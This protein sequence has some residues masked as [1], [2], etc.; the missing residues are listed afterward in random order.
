[1]EAFYVAEDHHHDYAARN[2]WQPY[3]RMV[4]APKVS[5]LREVHGRLLKAG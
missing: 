1:L 4:A 2:P 5:K 3:I